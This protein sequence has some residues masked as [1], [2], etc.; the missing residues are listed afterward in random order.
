MAFLSLPQSWIAVKKILKVSIF[1]YTKDNFDF[2][3][4]KI[5]GGATEPTNGSFEIDS[6]SDDVPD[7]WDWTVYNGTLAFDTTTPAHGAQAV[8]ITDPGGAGVGG[9]YL[10]SDYIEVSD[11]VTYFLAFLLKCSVAGVDTRVEIREYDK[12]KAYQSTQGLYSSTSNPTS[13]TKEQFSYAPAASIAYIKIRLIGGHTDTNQAGDIYFDDV[14]FGRT[15]VSTAQTNASTNVSSG[16]TYTFSAGNYGVF[17]AKDHV[18]GGSGGIQVQT[19]GGW[20]LTSNAVRIFGS[21][22]SNGSN[23]RS[24]NNDAAAQLVRYTT[25]D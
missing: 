19:G 18:F 13:W 17:D 12:V 22:T 9:G 25:I 10:D 3:F 11:I 2:L 14:I 8:K 7:N 15:I 4:S 16:A 1:Q 21:V 20:S 23:I 5:S 24:D 6:D